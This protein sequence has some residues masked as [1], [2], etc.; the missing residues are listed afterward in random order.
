MGLHLL[1]ITVYL[2]ADGL[3]VWMNIFKIDQIRR[4]ETWWAN[5]A[6]EFPGPSVSN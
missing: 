4:A 2:F 3:C 1:S 5:V 6:K